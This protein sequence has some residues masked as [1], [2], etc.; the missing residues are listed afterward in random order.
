MSA[1]SASVSP[2]NSLTVPTFQPAASGGACACGQSSGRSRRLFFHI[3]SGVSLQAWMTWNGV[4]MVFFSKT[5]R[6]TTRPGR[7]G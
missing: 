6:I 7:G 4:V 5:S 3:V 1:D 2:R